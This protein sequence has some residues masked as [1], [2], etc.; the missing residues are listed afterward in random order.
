ML[1]MERKRARR[2]LDAEMR[3][4]RRAG[5]EKNPTNGLLRAVRQALRVPVAEIAEKM[6]V[7]RSGVFD[8]ET[9]ERRNT[10]SLKS[11]SR[12]AD[13]M[14]CKVV[15]GIVPKDGKTLEELEEERLWRSVLGG[16]TE[17]RDQG[18]EIRERR[19]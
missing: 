19:G 12:M 16:G 11:M 18:S 8:L 7:N 4:Y 9:G 10:I 5:V 3:P 6:G 15:Y 2:E 14:G 13:A 1:D 17:I